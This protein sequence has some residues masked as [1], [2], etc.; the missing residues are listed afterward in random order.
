M[1]SSQPSMVLVFNLMN[2]DFRSGPAQRS[3]QLTHSLADQFLPRLLPLPQRA[4]LLLL[5]LSSLAA[6][7]LAR[8]AP[9]GKDHFPVIGWPPAPVLLAP[10][11]GAVAAPIAVPAAL[12][13][14]CRMLEV[15]ALCETITAITA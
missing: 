1:F 14:A 12:P 7:G 5:R 4:H 11:P 2:P 6:C 10:A 9:A 3:G 13:S 15:C 8:K